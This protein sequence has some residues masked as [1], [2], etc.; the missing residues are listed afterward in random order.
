MKKGSD[1]WRQAG[2]TS[3][4]SPGRRIQ[5]KKTKQSAAFSVYLWLLCSP[6]LV[7]LLDFFLWEVITDHLLQLRKKICGVN[8]F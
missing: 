8:S 5:R 1:E 4:S 6:A 7:P 3:H 2:L